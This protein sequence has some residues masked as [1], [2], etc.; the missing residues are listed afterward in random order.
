[1]RKKADFWDVLSLIVLALFAL[2]LI[3]PLS[4]LLIAGLRDAEGWTLAHL[5]RFF[6]KR[7]YYRALLNSLAVSSCVTLLSLLIGVPMAYAMTFWTVRGRR[8]LEMLIIVAMMS[9]PFIGAYSW[10]LI[11]GRNGWLTAFMLRTFGVHIPTIYGF[12]GIVLVLTMKLYPFIYIYVSGAMKKLDLS[13]VE[14]AQNLGM[15]GVRLITGAVMP[16]IAPTALSAALMVFMN[17]MADFGTPQLIGE[18]YVTL[19]VLVYTEFVNEMGGDT[20]FASAIAGLMVA[21]TAGVFLLQ[22]G[23]L[24]RRSYQ[25]SGLINPVPRRLS[26]AASRLMHAALYA[27]VLFSLLPQAIV[28][29]TSFLHA[30]RMV[31]LGGFS[32]NSYRLAFETLG[33]SVL[34]TLQLGGAAILIILV[35]GVVVSYLCVRR[36]GPLNNLI[37]VFAMFPYV[38][39]GSV[40]GITLLTAFGGKPWL[41]AGSGIIMV[42][43]LVI[44]RLPYTLRSSAAILRQ[45]PDNLEEASISLGVPP[46]DSFFRITAVLMI[47][48]VVSGAILSWVTVI[49]ELSSSVILYS[50]RTRTLSVAVYSEVVRGSYGTAAAL[51]TILTAVTVLS[52]LLASRISGRNGLRL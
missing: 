50:T 38:I 51:S 29:Y 12:H 25:S 17:S 8:V 45:I 52:L 24:E 11:C 34:H 30:N 26:A 5:V 48:G 42:L 18:G 16:L 39:P 7:Y 46:L 22:K 10:I 27:V 2:F 1:M 23:Y 49:N 19:P 33:T 43:S 3:A 14:A 41:L 9:P 36:K 32:L 44:R 6:S 20:H 35:M 4:S 37:D 15:G 28:C 31:F 13:L 47:P 40:L 21:L